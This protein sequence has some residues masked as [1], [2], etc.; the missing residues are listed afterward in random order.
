VAVA[1]IFIALSIIGATYVL[2]QVPPPNPTAAPARTAGGMADI[3][4]HV[5]QADLAQG[6][7]AFSQFG[8]TACH[9]TP[10]GVG[11]YVVGLGVRAGSRRPGY[12]AVAYLYES[13]VNPD[14]YIVPD[15]SPRL[16]PQNFKQ[17]IPEDQLYDLIA[18]LL[19]Q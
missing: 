9:G 7:K 12:N 6:E 1:V 14:T 2:S 16:M 8:C 13:I 5:E 18:W 10:N 15:Y 11:P 19:K 3:E 17:T 4:S